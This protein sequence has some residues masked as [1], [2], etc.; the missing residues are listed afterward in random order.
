MANISQ[1]MVTSLKTADPTRGLAEAASFNGD[2]DTT[3]NDEAITRNGDIVMKSTIA[4]VHRDACTMIDGA[5]EAS[6]DA[7]INSSCV[8]AAN[9]PSRAV[10]APSSGQHKAKCVVIFLHGLGGS[11]EGWLDFLGDEFA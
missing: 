3:I 6:G 11:G 7:D 5:S 8:T 9:G 1:G 10:D 2:S 4:A